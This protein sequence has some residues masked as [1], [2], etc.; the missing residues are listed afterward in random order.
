MRNIRELTLGFG[1]SELALSRNG[2]YLASGCREPLP[3]AVRGGARWRASNRSRP[4]KIRGHPGTTVYS[5]VLEEYRAVFRRLTQRLDDQD[6]QQGG[7]V[8]LPPRRDMANGNKCAGRFTSR[9]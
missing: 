3:F 6:R 1:P 7:R 9:Y 2:N 4:R 5:H 8:A